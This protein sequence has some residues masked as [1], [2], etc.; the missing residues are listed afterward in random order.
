MS[1]LQRFLK[2]QDACRELA[3]QHGP[4]FESDPTWRATER[5]AETA[6]VEAEAEAARQRAEVE[7]WE[8]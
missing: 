5:D 3:R 8:S 1:A 2:A 6:R 7:Q 4:G